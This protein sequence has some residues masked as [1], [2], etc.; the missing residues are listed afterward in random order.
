[1]A[2]FKKITFMA[3]SVVLAGLITEAAAYPALKTKLEGFKA[4]FDALDADNS[5]QLAEAAETVQELKAQLASALDIKADA[6]KKPVVEID[7]QKY[8]VNHGSHPH[9]AEKISKDPELAKSILKIKG[10]NVLSVI[11]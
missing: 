6:S 2:D 5:A 1:M 4:D 11:A 7:G 3:L 10:Q 9:S 8:E